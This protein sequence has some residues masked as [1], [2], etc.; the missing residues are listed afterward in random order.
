MAKKILVIED[1]GQVCK[2]LKKM[3]EAVNELI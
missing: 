1:D 2:M 3:L